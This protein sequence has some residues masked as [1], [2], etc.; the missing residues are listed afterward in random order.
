MGSAEFEYDALPKALKAMR[1]VKD[2]SW[3]PTIIK[4]DGHVAWYVGPDNLYNIAR[5]LFIGQL[6]EPHE[7]GL[8]DRTEIQDKYGLSKWPN[9]QKNV[10]DLVGW[11]DILS[12]YAIFTKKKYAKQWIDSLS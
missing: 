2:S 4:Y 10:E 5:E 11:W 8:Q 9:A 1:E 12:T 7:A 6:T 3:R